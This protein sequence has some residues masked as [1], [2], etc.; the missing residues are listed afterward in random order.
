M[1]ILV[2]A[3][4]K[5]IHS[6]EERTWYISCARTFWTG[7]AGSSPHTL[8][9]FFHQAKWFSSDEFGLLKRSLSFTKFDW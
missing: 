8:L 6:W 5:I 7:D 4:M 1:K 9:W 2:E 3:F